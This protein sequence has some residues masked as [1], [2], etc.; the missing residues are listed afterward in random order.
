[1]TDW[2]AL[3]RTAHAEFTARV[4]AVTD[5]D[6]PTPDTEWS[7]RDLVAHVV[8]DQQWV[9]LL[10]AGHSNAEARLAIQPLGDDLALEWH[11]HSAAALAAFE[12]AELTS[13]VHLE[14]D[15]V[16]ASDYLAELAG[17]VTIHTWDLARATGA[18]EELDPSLVDAVWGVFE[19]QADDLAQS[20]LYAPVVPVASDAPLQVRLLAL[21]G[22]AAG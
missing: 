10:L 4:A 8:D 11:R 14:R 3:L 2:I 16:S 9:P 22:R 13:T 20:G 15:V 5:W 12:R 1:M 19:P 7:V 6:S 21:T 17:D 18:S